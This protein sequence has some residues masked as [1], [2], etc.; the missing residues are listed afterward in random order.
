MDDNDNI[1][2]L[3]TSRQGFDV[4]RHAEGEK[5]GK[6]VTIVDQ[7]NSDLNKQNNDKIFDNEPLYI[8][9]V[10]IFITISKMQII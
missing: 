10:C 6:N 9:F 2:R 4:G 7:V 8:I 3:Q 5:G 1:L